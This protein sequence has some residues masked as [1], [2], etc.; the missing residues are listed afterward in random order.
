MAFNDTSKINISLKKLAG[1]AHTSNNKGLANEGLSSGITQASS[2]IFGEAIPASPTTTNLYDRSGTGENQVELVRF[3]C[4]FIAGTDTSSGRHAFRLK[5]P[6]DYEDGSS[7]GPTGA[8]VN[9]A[10]VHNSNSALQLVPPSF[11]SSYEAKPFYGGSSTKNSGTQIAVLDNRDWNIDY[12]NGI[13]FQQDPPGSGDHSNNP[14][15]V[16]AFLYIGKYL[17][18]VVAAGGGGGSGDITSVVAGNGL[19]GG[20]TS[21]PATVNIGAGTGINVTSDSIAVN[22]GIVATLTGSELTSNFVLASDNASLTNARV[23][24]AGDGI[25]ITTASPRQIKVST[26]RTKAFFDVTGSH[27]SESSFDCHG[28]N[29]SNVDYNPNL[30]DVFYN[31]VSMRSGSSHDYTLFSTGSIKF[32]F[33]L[34]LDD[35]IQIIV[36]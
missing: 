14:D 27:S 23:I 5:L 2:T 36:F 13:I 18:T 1:K 6:P 16:E 11:G 28:L 9:N 12:Y 7:H 29:F 34:F 19:T 17:D 26:S 35:T 33:E 25:T 22:D 15:F 21:G 20:A 30:I 24:T 32:K 31:G 10:V 3:A 8:Y 4:E